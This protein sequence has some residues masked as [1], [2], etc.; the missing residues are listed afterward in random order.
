MPHGLG[1]FMGIDTHD[2]GG[3]P[4]GKHK[5]QTKDGYKSLRCCVD[6]KV[7]MIL[8]VE[9]GIYF[10]DYCIDKAIK[11]CP[12][13]FNINILNDY[14]GF[15]GIRLEDNVLITPEGCENLTRCAR[16][17][18]DIEKVMSGKITSLNDLN[19]PFTKYY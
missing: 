19:C 8:T 14:R 11:E 3:R 18:E 7:G 6:M 13:F 17:V 15:G 10:N 5:K 9:P 12:Q 4:V 1:H 2:T 16:T